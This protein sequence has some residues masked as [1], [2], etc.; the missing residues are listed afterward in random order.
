[1]TARTRGPGGVRT[2]RWRG[3]AGFV[4]LVLVASLTCIVAP[5]AGAWGVTGYASSYSGNA[6]GNNQWSNIANIYSGSDSNATAAWDGTKSCWNGFAWVACSTTQTMYLENFGFGSGTVP[7]GLTNL[8]VQVELRAYMAYYNCCGSGWITV[9]PQYSNDGSNWFD[10]SAYIYRAN[11]LP[12]NTWY[13]DTATATGFTSAQVR[14][15]YFR[16][17]VVTSSNGVGFGLRADYVKATVLDVT[18]PTAGYVNDG[19]GADVNYQQSTSTINA[20]WSGFSDDW[21]GVASYSYAI[22]TTSGG[23]NVVNWTSTG[24]STSVTKNSLSLSNGT[25]YYVSVRA[26]DTAGNVS[27]VATSDGVTVD[28]SGP[29]AGTVADGLSTDVNWQNSTT[30]IN[31]NWSGFTDA[32]SGVASYQY[33]IG[34]TSGGT[35]VLGWTNNGS[36]TSVTNSSLTLSAGT[37]YYVSVKATDNVGNTGSAANSNGVTVDTTNPVAG[38]VNDGSGA[39]VTWQG[40]TSTIQANWSGFSDAA[41]GVAS[42]EYAIG[43]T[44]GGTQVL[45]WTSNASATS[46][47]NSSLTLANGTTYYVSVRATDTAGNTSAVATSNG[48][49]VDSTAPTA[50]SVNDGPG[51]DLT[52]QGATTTIWANW[53]GFS[54]AASG[55]TG[56]EYAIGTTS[57]GTQTV[58]WTSNA[59]AT[60]VTRNGLTLSDGT[61]YYVSVRATDTA[62]NTSVATSNGVTVDAT[63]PVAGTVADGTSTDV[64]WQQSTTTINANWSGFADVTSGIA[65]YQYA[66]GTTSGGTQLVDWTG[67][68]TATSVTRNGLTLS[69]GTTYYV[70]VRAVDSASNVSVP[71]TSNGVTVD[72]TAPVA[73]TVADGTSTDVTWQRSTGTISANWSGFS[74]PASGIASY[75]YAIG[76]TSGGTQVAGWTSTGT[77]TS[78]TRNGLTLSNGTTYYVSVRATDNVGNTSTVATSNGVTV[79]TTAPVAGTVADGT[80][81]DVTWQQSTTTIDANWTGFSDPASGIASYEYAIGTTA[82]GTQVSGWT[83]TG[84]ATSVTRNGLT[85]SNGTTYYVSVRATDTAGNTSTVATS[86][87]VTVDTTAPVAGPVNDGTGADVTWQQSTT[88]IDANW[89]GFSDPASG[90]ASYGYAIGTTAGGTQIVDWT[91]TGTATS[92]TRNGLTLSN[93]TTYYVSVRATDTA[94]NTSTVATSNGVTVDTTAPTGGTVNDGTG[95]DLEWQRSSGTLSA[96]WSGFSDAGSGIDHYQWAIGLSP[97]GTEVLPWT[98]VGAVTSKTLSGLALIDGGTYYVSVRAVDA[99]GNVGNGVGSNGITIDT[100][101]PTQGT[102]ADG[103]GADVDWQQSTSRIDANWTGFGDVGSG[104]TSYEYAIGTTSGGTQ[105]VD[106][107]STGTATSVAKTGLSLTGGT[108]Y[109]V[110]VRGLDRAGNTSETATSDGVTVDASAPVAGTVADGTS[111]DI[112]WQRSTGTIS[113]NWSGFSDPASG[114]ASYEYA[115]GTTSG[116]TQLVDWTSTG[117][118]TSFTRT[119]LTLSNGTTYYVSVRATDTAGNVSSVATSN[120]VTVD[121]TAPTTGTVADGTSTDVTWQRSTGTISANWSGYTDPASG[122]ASYEYAIGTTAGGTQTVDWTSTGTAT[123]V[124][125]NGLT[126]SNGTEYFVSVRATDAAGNVGSAA[127]SNG[128]TVD[129]TAPTIDSVADGTGADITWQR[130][131]SSLSANWTGSDIGSGVASYEYA[132]GTTSGGTDVVDW[133]STGTSTSVTRNGLTLSNGTAYFVSVRVTDTAG[134][135]STVATSN[136]VTVDTTAPTTGSVADGTSSDVTWQRST[137][138]LS[139]NWTGFADPAS[140]IASYEYAIGTT[141]GATDVADWTSNASATSVTRNGLSLSNGTTYYVS[142]RATDQVGNTSSVATSNGVTVDHTTPAAG[143]VADGTSTDVTWQQSTTTINANWTG[144]SDPASGIASYEYAIGT[145]A[146]GTQIVDWTSTGTATNVTETGLSLGNGTTY[147]VSVRATDQ[148]GN[149]G[150]A[151]TSNGV[152]V[153]HTAPSTGTVADGTSTDVTW[154]RSTT[155]IDANWTGFAD[156]ASGIASYEYAIGTTAGGTDLVDWTGV[157]TATSVTRNDLTLSNGTE[158]FVSVRATDTVGNVSSVATSNGVTVDHTAP[159]TGTVNDGSGADVTWQTSTSTIDANWTGFADPASGIASYE[160]AIGT[161][162]GGTQ[163]VDWTDNGTATSVTRNGLTLSNG[164]TYY[165]SVRATDQVGNTSTTATSNG[166]TVDT[167]AP[168]AGTVNDGS[169]TDITW[170]RSTTTIDANWS[171]FTATSGI[172]HYDYAIGTTPAATDIAGWTSTGTATTVTRNGLTLSDGTTYYVTVRATDSLGRTAAASSDGVTADTTAPVA[173]T[174]ADGTTTDV[175]WQRSTTSLS[176]NWSGF[177]DPAS[178]IASYEY[179]IGTTSGGTQLVGWTSTATA[180]SFTRNGL[181]LS[182]GT[183]YYVSVRATDTVGN[184]STVATSNGVTVDTTAPSTGTVNDGLSADVTWQTSTSTVDANWTGFA[185]PASGIASYEYAIGTTSGGTDIVDWTSTGT[186]TTVTKT[187]LA[188][189]NGTTYYVSVRATDQVGNTSTVATSNGVTVD[190]TAPSTGTVNDGTG[191]DVDWQTTA[192]FEANWTGFADGGSGIDH[193]DYAIGTTPGG[194]DTVGWTGVGTAT[195]ASTAD[196]TFV[197]GRTYYVSVRAT[198]TAGNVS[199]IASSDGAELRLIATDG[200]DSGSESSYQSATDSF[201]ADWTGLAATVG[202]EATGF[203]WRVETADGTPVTDWQSVGLSTHATATGLTLTPGTRYVARVRVVE[204]DQSVRTTVVT[205]GSTIDTAPPAAGTIT[206]TELPAAPANL[207][208][209]LSAP[210]ARQYVASWSGF[211]DAISGIAGYAWAVGTAPGG[212]DL[213]D[214]S[215]VGTADHV[216]FP[217][218]R[219]G[220]FSF[221]LRVKD[222]AGNLVVVSAPGGAPVDPSPSPSPTTEPSPTTRPSTAPPSGDGK[223]VVA[224]HE[225]AHGDGSEPATATTARRQLRGGLPF[226]GAELA[227]TVTL[228]LLLVFSGFVLIRGSRRRRQGDCGASQ[229]E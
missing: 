159:S 133:T 216:V 37:K 160:Y 203:E 130:S 221:S 138:S 116:G 179:A 57:G 92:V 48:V 106:W 154:Q 38:T 93:G 222:H 41:S 127:T 69:N 146:G 145:T 14:D 141:P 78:V 190:T 53:S 60:S 135:T 184:T 112:T 157:G 87:G 117:T 223:A 181:T 212:N 108:T 229:R 182:N 55:L 6:A 3:T 198:D 134:N 214:W 208:G 185:D 172:D 39:D 118:A 175:G 171:G 122:I 186:A 18:A 79:D 227:A 220:S 187:G 17:K 88:T 107:T 75:D 176:A 54:D 98:N 121:T 85:L 170:Q 4:A 180:T 200:P 90:I 126:L 45:G 43:T 73:G 158:Y 21:S 77:A 210:A 11:Y 76:T 177:S 217:V 205:S 211:S 164:T 120:G 84:T 101:A 144:F 193:Y 139:A 52:W 152:T 31:A 168:V 192:R 150:S 199:T 44:S 50:G 7:N 115:I 119:G 97:C 128:V 189:G 147:Y 91:S 32:V 83:S 27:S 151:A 129:T 23:T 143:T 46:V 111:T 219:T 40:S 228:A 22:G 188:L 25:K 191:P 165:V 42:Y 62:G 155:T 124:T 8:S 226:T 29:A 65:G 224:G 103:N 72:T 113:A 2:A 218:A 183:T 148:V 163:L 28:T 89:S 94:G 1:M 105:V 34:T 125:R 195:S 59:S 63:A 99:V 81:N 58:N 197:V 80:S 49:T 166:V 71:A 131:T 66:I 16:V 19:V 24:A 35:Q 209:L 13:T 56:Y 95:A 206:V 140:G 153:D 70:S 110:S 82:G 173:G 225:A 96:N 167:N 67:V 102:V 9:T 142:V 104:V 137:S 64:T 15:G 194:T 136:G 74:D 178:G 161:T 149:T 207:L 196:A 213:T 12:V 20:N 33:A 132:I 61:T 47:T 109:Y 156:P 86:N 5:R 30:T 68:G 215:D 174:V 114:I 162:S 26:T 169:G 123:S 202:P 36:A 204:H 51:A 10:G 201:S 100:S